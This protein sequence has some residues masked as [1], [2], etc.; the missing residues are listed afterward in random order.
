MG[1][2]L[3]HPLDQDHSANPPSHP[4]LLNLLANEFAAHKF[5]VKWL[6]RE[7]AMS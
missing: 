2:G 5:D 4:E 3:I 7:I 1:R 6:V